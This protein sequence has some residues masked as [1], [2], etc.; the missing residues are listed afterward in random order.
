MVHR[1]LSL[2]ALALAT[3]APAAL[4]QSHQA[5]SFEDGG[6]TLVSGMMLFLGND[7]KVYILDK[8]E[9]NSA[10]ING[11]PAF[12]AVYD[13]ASR[14]A[15]VMDIKTNAFCSS[16]MHLPNGSYI[17]LGGNGAIGPGGNIS[18][19]V[20]P[21]SGGT[22]GTFSTV[23]QD[24]DGGKSIRL[25]NPCTGS[26]DPTSSQCSWYD[27]PTVLS[28]QSRRWYS[29][30]EPMADGTIAIIGGF[31]N[32]G[33]INRNYPNVDPA[34]EGG[35]ANPTFEFFP[36]RGPPQQMQFIIDTSGL[37]SY[38]HT[39]NM[40]SGKMFLQANVSTM[41]WD[42]IANQETRLPNMPGDIVR[43]YP[44]SGAAAML[45]LTPA[46]NWNPTL[47]FC[48]GSD[49]PDEAWGNYSWP[50]INTWEYPASSKCHRITP[51]P[52]DSSPVDYVNDDDMLESRTMGQ[53]IILPDLT[54]M[55]FNGGM[56]GTAG[57]STQ[58]LLTQS[59][60]DMPYGMSL[61]S[62]PVGTP[63]L[64]NPNAPAGQRWSNAGFQTSNIPRLYHSSALLLPDASVM[65]AG[66]NPNVDVNMTTFFPTTYKAEIFYPAY[67]SAKSR[68]APQGIPQTL[69]Y[70]GASF[71]ITVP[72]SSYTGS[73]NDAADKAMVTVIRPGWTT[74]AMNMGQRGLQLNSTY[75]VNQDGSITLH[76]AQ[77]PPNPNLVQPG[78]ALLF[79]VIDGIPSNGTML[80][81]G[82]GQIG[83]QPTS[84]AS[85][86]P[87]SVRLD[88]ATGTGAGGSTT[89]SSN[90]TTSTSGSSHLGPIIG[91]I[92][93]GIALV[94]ILGAIFG[95]C[96]A[97]RRRAAAQQNPASSYPMGAS[98]GM[99]GVGAAMASRGL[100]SSDSS[101]FVPLQQD[102]PSMAWDANASSLSVNTPYKDERGT[103]STEFDP[104]YQN[105]PR[106]STSHNGPRYS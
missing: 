9:G 74:H 7:E 72:A 71:D 76:V 35:A 40:P 59:Y 88:T 14:T 32:G 75:T 54:M 30:A 6:D 65:I 95:I 81:V 53:F 12:G 93:G 16:G 102:N 20:D 43:V 97:R 28:M 84:A 106:M 18:D 25:L 89:N 48:G 50:Y 46:N 79:V 36:S 29:T 1:Q 83:T 103:M 55:V 38:P 57:Y 2:L 26:F 104:Y 11:H 13:I 80:I 73:A 27:D 23:Y 78:P 91:G 94:G 101:A 37:N 19:Q 51:E 31:T 85:T 52:T 98:A 22:I 47:I 92:V 58:T 64:Y 10:Q 62:G 66:S 60:A 87:P 39:F 34:N 63:A 21:N 61:A 44:A 49:M 45:P 70:G 105:A 68:P 42:P 4:A 24:S 77:L 100:R 56:N 99:S 90:D 3:L 15:T 86:L 5:G 8:A 33:Y 17:T 82:N 69:S 41:L 96:L 67:F